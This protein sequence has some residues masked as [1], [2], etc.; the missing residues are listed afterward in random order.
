V[1]LRISQLFRVPSE[2]VLDTFVSPR[3]SVSA[4]A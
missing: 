1:N 4:F 3:G 2:G